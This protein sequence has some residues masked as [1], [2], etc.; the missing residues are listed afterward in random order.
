ARTAELRALLEL[1]NTVALT[2]DL[3]PQLEAVLT[4]LVATADVNAAEV[5]ELEADGRLT[6]VASLGIVPER[7]LSLQAAATDDPGQKRA[8]TGMAST[9]MVDDDVLAL[10]LRARG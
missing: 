6:P 5:L 1:S 9:A 10:P 7:Q 8:L 3:Q 2:T 4:R